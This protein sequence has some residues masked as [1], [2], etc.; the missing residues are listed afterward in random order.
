ME[1]QKKDLVIF[2][3]SQ[4]GTAEDYASRIARDAKQ[5]GFEPLIA[6]FEDYDFV[7]A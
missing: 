1:E 7:R 4:T 3:G 6:D 5:F 2:F